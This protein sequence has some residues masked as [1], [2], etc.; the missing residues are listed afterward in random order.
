MSYQKLIIQGNIGQIH[1][2]RFTPAGDMVLGFSVA[3]SEGKDKPTTWFNCTAF[4]KSGEFVQK[5]FNK[6]D[7][8]IV[9][10]RIK[11]E[12]YQGKDGTE[13]E[14]WKVDVDKVA[15]AGG[16]REGGEVEPTAKARPVNKSLT[17][18]NFESDIP[19]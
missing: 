12:K 15:F 8:M 1:E 11:C 4:K 7:G 10:G 18:K 3:Y 2:A 5:Y 16:K 14:S 13:K 6:G 17:N 19:F 9:E